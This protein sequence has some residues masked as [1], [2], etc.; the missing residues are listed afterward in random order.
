MPADLIDFNDAEVLPK[1]YGGANGGKICVLYQGEQYMIKYPAHARVNENLSYAHDCI[2]EHL[3]CSIFRS[4]GMPT[5]ET[6]LGTRRTTNGKDSLVVACRDLTA[7]DTMLLQDFASLK[8][9]TIP[10]TP[11]SGYGVEL[12]EIEDTFQ[13]QQVFDPQE[14]ADR[15]WDMFIVDAF[16]GN[17]D[18]HNG[19]WGYLYDPHARTAA[20]APVY[21]CGSSLYALAD[22]GVM[23]ETLN[24]RA[25]MDFRLFERPVSAICIGG[26]KLKYFDFL[27]SLENENCNAALERVVPRLKLNNVEKIIEDAP[28]LS[29]LQRDFYE[30]M[31]RERK[32]RILNFAWQKLQARDARA[33]KRTRTRKR[34]AER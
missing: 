12:S 25:A 22:D 32:D 23:R 11:R 2:A 4:A 8:N 17:W 24:D 1:G 31:L 15:F 6:I 28:G 5:Q 27:A 7:Q 26:K 19:N 9:Q 13:L 10:G 21:D 30:I 18:R 14:I 20:L 34:G 3:G 29:D 33:A 16:I